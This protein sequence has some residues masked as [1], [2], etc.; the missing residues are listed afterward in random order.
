[1]NDGFESAQ[2]GTGELKFGES[3]DFDFGEVS[4][5]LNGSVPN[6][7]LRVTG[8]SKRIFPLN[9]AFISK[10]SSAAVTGTIKVKADQLSSCLEDDNWKIPVTVT[11]TGLKSITVKTA[12]KGGGE[13]T[14]PRDTAAMTDI[15][16]WGIESITFKEIGIKCGVDV[17]QRLNS[18]VMDGLTVRIEGT[19][20]TTPVIDGDKITRRIN[21]A[22]GEHF[23]T[24][25]YK[26]LSK[27]DIEGLKFQFKANP[28]G[29]IP[30]PLPQRLLL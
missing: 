25:T 28:R 22:K 18:L 13:S 4:L 19:A 30:L 1:L 17:K 11:I 14:P 16:D 24:G 20:G 5:T 10:D 26:T 8:D 3:D 29:M 7:P 6:P 27:S 2:I 12:E 23:F 21:T 15:T 9:D